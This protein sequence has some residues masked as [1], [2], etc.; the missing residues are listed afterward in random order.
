M[1][2]TYADARKAVLEAIRARTTARSGEFF[3][4][5]EILLNAFEALGKFGDEHGGQLLMDAYDD[6]FVQRVISNGGN[7]ANIDQDRGHLTEHGQATVDELD[8]DPA[9]QGAYARLVEP[10]LVDQPI[11]L[12]YLR[13]A[14]ATYNH[15]HYKAAAVLLGCASEALSVSLRDAVV[16]KLN[17]AG[18][19][20]PQD[21]TDWRMARVLNALEVELESR[22]KTM[23]ADLKGR[24]E[25]FW[26][27]WTGLFR[28]TRN[29][30]GHPS[31]VE[32]VTREI[33]RG[34]LLFFPS[35]AQLVADLHAWVGTGL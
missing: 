7:R 4:R 10:H 3:H 14:V 15:G 9:N 33:V 32:P 23:P 31:S 8:R 29:E 18:A 20:L 17:A 26:R 21:L 19:K 12:S 16:A 24:Y 22:K 6:L 28:M 11:A 27:A 35:H 5:R 34:S 30:V 25:A 2:V 1:P 13:E